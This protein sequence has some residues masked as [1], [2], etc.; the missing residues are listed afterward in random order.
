[1]TDSL[2]ALKLFGRI[3]RTGSFSQAGRELGI[4]QPSTSRLIVALEKSI[5]AALITR[6]TR[7]VVLTETGA[8][9]LARIEPILAALEEANQTARGTGELR[10]NLRIGGSSG[11]LTRRII[12]L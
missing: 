12:G 7:A 1:M 8:E 10:G 2:V 6:T 4:P 11:L 5:G 3:A 9:Y